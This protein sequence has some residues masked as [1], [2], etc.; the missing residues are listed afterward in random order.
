[1][2]SVAQGH[3]A[4]VAL[5]RGP[6]RRVCC[7]TPGGRAAQPQDPDSVR[8][9]RQP[10]ALPLW[11]HGKLGG[12]DCVKAPRGPQIQVCGGVCGLHDDRSWAGLWPGPQPPASV[13][14][15]VCTLPSFYL[16]H[17]SRLP[18]LPLPPVPFWITVPAFHKG[19]LR[20]RSKAY[21]AQISPL[22]MA[23]LG[24][25]PLSQSPLH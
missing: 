3:S 22:S 17:L 7:S 14:P 4:S 15:L 2:S 11:A 21:L 6:R 13:F 25:E 20:L 16:H 10:Q 23:E 5:G 1:M 18:A 24:W 9:D 12:G 8:L 19:K